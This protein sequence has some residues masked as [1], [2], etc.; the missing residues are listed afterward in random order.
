MEMESRTLI[1]KFVFSISI[2]LFTFSGLMSQISHSISFLK[3]ELTFKTK[4]GK[5]GVEYDIVSI[6][7]LYL[8]Y[9][10]G[11]PSLPVKYIK[12]IIPSDQDA[13]KITLNN[14]E[15]ETLSEYYKIYPAQPDIPSAED[16]IEP[17]FVKPDPEIYESDNPWPDETVKIIHQGYLDGSNHILTLAIYPLRYYPKSG[18]LEFLSEIDFV[19]EMEKAKTNSMLVKRRLE[20]N[21]KIYNDILQNIVENQQDINLYQQK[22]TEA[23][24]DNIYSVPF[25]EYVIVTD[26]CLKS[27]FNKFIN[28][29]KRKGINIGVVTIQSIL[30]NYTSGDLIS[31]INDA[32]GN[33]RQY[34]YNSWQNG[35]IW[36]LFAGDYSIIPVRYGA[37]YNDCD[38]ENYNENSH[39]RIPN[40]L[41][42]ADFNGDW[43]VDGIDGDNSIRYGEPNNDHPDYNPELFIGRLLCNNI[44]GPNDILNWTHKVIL[45]DQNPGKGDNS[46]LTKAFSMQS[47]DQQKDNQ[48]NNIIT[49]L[50]NSFIHTIYSEM[51]SYNSTSPTYPTAN[52]VI[53]EMNNHYGLWSWFAHASPNSVVAMSCSTNMYPRYK[54]NTFD[55]IEVNEIIENGDALENLNNFNYPA[56]LYS[57]ACDNNPFDDFQINFYTGRNLGEGFTVI[58]KAGGPAFLGNTRY[59]WVSSSAALYY[60]FADLLKSAGNDQES[61]KSFLH[62][63]VSEM[64]SKSLYPNHYLKY[65]HNLIGCPETMIWTAIPSNFSNIV[66]TDNSNSITV[67][68][69]VTNCLISV[70]SLDNGQ[71]FFE[72]VDN[73]TSYTFNTSIRPL[74]ITVTKPNYL[75]F[76]GITGGN[77]TSNI[78]LY[79]L[80]QVLG[81]ITVSNNATLAI[82]DG[83]IIKFNNGVGINVN[84]GSII[85]TGAS[86]NYCEFISTNVNPANSDWN[87]IVISGSAASA[88]FNYCQV[89]NAAAGI[90]FQNGASGNIFNSIIDNN[91]IGISASSSVPVIQNC[92]INDN[93][94]G[95]QLVDSYQYNWNSV[96]ISS[97]TIANNTEYGLYLTNSSP[98]ISGNIISNNNKGMHI[99]YNSNPIL[100]SN[101]IT[102]SANNGIFCYQNASPDIYYNG[103]FEV[104]GYN[105]ITYNGAIGVKISAS[106]NPKLGQADPML[107]GYNSIYNNSSY[108]IKN[109]TAATVYAGSNWWNNPAGPQQG[110]IFGLVNWQPPLAQAP[111]GQ[112]TMSSGGEFV[113]DAKSSLPEDLQQA[114]YEQ[115]NKK[116]EDSAI[117]FK[118]HFT[119]KKDDLFNAEATIQYIKSLAL[120]KSFQEVVDEIEKTLKDNLDEIVQYELLSAQASHLVKA[121]QPKT[122]LEK[123]DQA[124]T[125]KID[126]GQKNRLLFQKSF[127]YNY[128]I[129]DKK[130]AQSC[131]EDIMNN[132]AKDSDDYIL[133]SEELHLL[134]GN[135]G[136]KNITLE[137]TANNALGVLETLPKEYALQGN[138]PNP[139]NPSTT[140][141]FALPY[142]SHVSISIYNIMGQLINTIVLSSVS[143]GYRDVPWDGKN[144]Q[145]DAV[146]SGIYI[147]RFKAVSLEGNDKHFEKVAKMI[148]VR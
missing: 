30:A 143:A 59:G 28:W 90:T 67:N 34:L 107:G 12:L 38:W 24:T 88:A 142:Q 98:T 81:N 55:S 75:P 101:Q 50:P 37:G 71:G 87:G 39:Y 144:M 6:E 95:V 148:L 118:F 18:R 94:Y 21:S 3:E 112:R 4:I 54:V 65:S 89:K 53:N 138:Y 23:Q 49:H 66:V 26:T 91:V 96:H 147:Y 120:Y 64:V 32:A 35:T 31:G 42:F 72:V 141:R 47:D 139:F 5:D 125:L 134:N 61:G 58:I 132:S 113:Y 110:D 29:K 130:S 22:Q 82:E 25:Y 105:I 62:L 43:D 116:H 10:E 36:A 8:T 100:D 104:G 119:N 83:A 111:S 27:S 11:K 79:G 140:I 48:A 85:T 122:A 63:G 117:R 103:N 80:L 102:G 92:T 9:E 126:Q 7:N 57:C 133:A 44:T 128:N 17:E 76:I 13:F 114:Y 127:I 70:C 99:G 40:D 77:I 123:L 136:S 86:D 97:N 69:N 52:A 41:Y 73:S 33:L 56:I 20:K 129:D 16:Y 51:P 68:T 74:Y 108:E 84:S 106:S 15:K 137:K 46:Y 45:Y 135:T 60:K 78:N 19:I 145:G 1:S 115:M 146:S 109:E 2:V 14:A 121:D 131:L 93:S 124:M